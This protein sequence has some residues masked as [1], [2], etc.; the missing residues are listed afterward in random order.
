MKR[1]LLQSDCEVSTYTAVSDAVANASGACRAVLPTHAALTQVAKHLKTRQSRRSVPD[2]ASF[3]SM[4]SFAVPEQMCLR[5]GKNVLVADELVGEGR[6]M[7][8]QVLWCAS[9]SLFDRGTQ[10]TS[11]S[12]T[13][14][15]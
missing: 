9:L 10:I 12:W 3:D 8:F 7:I 4:A 14:E 5:D 13:R 1:S 11:Y 6:I 15:D 2:G